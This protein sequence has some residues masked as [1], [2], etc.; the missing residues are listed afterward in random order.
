M[1]K[2][3]STKGRK[4]EGDRHDIKIPHKDKINTKR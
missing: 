1:W 4:H 3:T 2:K